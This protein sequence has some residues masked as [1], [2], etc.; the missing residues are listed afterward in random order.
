MMRT[1]LTPDISAAT[2][3]RAGAGEEAR[4][5]AAW[6]LRGVAVDYLKTD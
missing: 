5:P 6:A 3:L 1:T 4:W 2:L